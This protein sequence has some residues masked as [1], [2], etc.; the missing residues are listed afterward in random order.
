MRQIQ[1]CLLSA[2]LLVATVAIFPARADVW[3]AAQDHVTRY[4]TTGEIV[5][6]ISDPYGVPFKIQRGVNL[7]SVNPA[8]RHRVGG[9]L[10]GND[11]IVLLSALAEQ[12]LT[13]PINAYALA[14]APDG[15]SIWVSTVD[16]DSGDWRLVEL[17][18]HTGAQRVE[19]VG[20]PR[21]SSTLA[22]HPD[23]TAG[24]EET[25]ALFFGCSAPTQS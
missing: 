17:D 6:T 21:Q 4:A 12:L 8:R 2:I 15:A 13:V 20:M 9:R 19:V 11:R 23:G 25:T 5:A 24:R 7:I 1:R 3:L 14:I 22:V 16:F 10:R 18:A